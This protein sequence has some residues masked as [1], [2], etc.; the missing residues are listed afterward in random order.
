[1]EQM[2]I[3]RANLGSVLVTKLVSMKCHQFMFQ[4]IFSVILQNYGKSLLAQYCHHIRNTS[5]I[6]EHVHKYMYHN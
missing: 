6:K 1:M 2:K 3:P 4:A 5:C